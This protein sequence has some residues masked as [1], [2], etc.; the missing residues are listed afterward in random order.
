VLQLNLVDQQDNGRITTNGAN[1]DS[2]DGSDIRQMY[3]GDTLTV[4][5]QGQSVTITGVTFYLA[6]GRVLFTPTDGTRLFDATFTS[7]TFVNTQGGLGVGVFSPPCFTPGTLIA[8]PAGEQEVETLRAGDRVKTM[9]HGPQRL[10]WAGRCTVSGRRDFAPVRI[11]AGVFGNRRPL[12]VSP[13]HRMLLTGWQAELL[14][15]EPS[16]LVSAKHLVGMEGVA[17]APCDEV[18]YIHLLFDCHEIIFAEG[19]PTESFHPGGALMEQDVAVREEIAAL[20]PDAFA[21]G[22]DLSAARWLALGYEARA[23]RHCTR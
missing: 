1:G 8:T 3:P 17:Y 2:V 14:F 23:L 11:A 19:A 10:R 20:F 9:D 21:G 18:D 22:R 13:N 7:S 12:V 5:M 6:D 15:G 4:T 16:I